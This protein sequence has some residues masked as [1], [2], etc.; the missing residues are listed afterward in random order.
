[1]ADS[2]KGVP[3]G[4][5]TFE[6]LDNRRDQHIYPNLLEDKNIDAKHYSG[7]RQISNQLRQY[8]LCHIDCLWQPN[9]LHQLLLVS[10]KLILH[11][12]L[13]YQTARNVQN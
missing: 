1:M 7:V 3:M 10:V 9:E 11:W 4:H 12:Q 2:P 8:H 5:S 13:K 6:P